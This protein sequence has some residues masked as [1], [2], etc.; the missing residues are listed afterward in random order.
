MI[1]PERRKHLIKSY[2]TKTR[3]AYYKTEAGKRGI[4][5]S[6]LIKIAL[7]EYFEPKLV[8]E[9][10]IVRIDRTPKG[11]TSF[12]DLKEI[13]RSADYR[14]VMVELKQYF[15]KKKRKH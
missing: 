9:S 5:V 4:G 8:P 14:G 12:T 1:K 2:V 3:K 15:A 10:A 11:R 13:E 6:E 7:F